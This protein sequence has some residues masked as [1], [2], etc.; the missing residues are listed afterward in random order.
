MPQVQLLVHSLGDLPADTPLRLTVVATCDAVCLRKASL[1]QGIRPPSPLQA[2]ASIYCGLAVHPCAPVHFMYSP[3]TFTVLSDGGQGQGKGPADIPP[4]PSTSQ[5]SP[6][7]R[8]TVGASVAAGL[9]FALMAAWWYKRRTGTSSMPWLEGSAL[10]RALGDYYSYT[11]FAGSNGLGGEEI[12][13]LPEGSLEGHP[14][15]RRV[16]RMG[17]D[18][19]R[20]A[21]MGLSDTEMTDAAAFRGAGGVASYTNNP[22]HASTTTGIHTDIPPQRVPHVWRALW[23]VQH[24]TLACLP[25]SYPYL[26]LILLILPSYTP[27][28]CRPRRTSPAIFGRAVSRPR[29]VQGRRGSGWRSRRATCWASPS[30]SPPHRETHPRNR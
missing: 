4:S 19:S 18:Y 6:L 12:G 1:S 26:P 21:S 8:A 13:S 14:H 27:L 16:V 17:R 5:W 28:G 30:P 2:N 9:A 22:M 11:Y 20:I 25:R 10:E 29:R 23:Q 7:F 3:V 15:G 24:D